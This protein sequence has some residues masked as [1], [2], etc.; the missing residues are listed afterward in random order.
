[1]NYCVCALL[2]NT[3]V[4]TAVLEIARGGMLR[5]GLPV[6]NVQAAIITNVAEDH[7]GEYGVL[8]LSDM[9]ETKFIIQHGLATDGILVLNADD[10]V[11]VNY[12][13]NV[14]RE[15]CW[16]SLDAADPTVS[17]HVKKGGK[18]CTIENGQIIYFENGIKTALLDYHRI[19]LTMDGAAV[20][21]NSNCLGAIS[22][23]KALGVENKAIADS[24]RTFGSSYTDNPGR[25]NIFKKNGY[26]ILMDFAHN[27]HGMNALVTLV[28]NIP[29]K[30]KLLLIG[31]AG[32]RN[33]DEIARLVK[34]AA[35]IKPDQ[36]I[37]AEI[38]KYLRG[39][40][41]GEIPDVISTCLQE[42]G[43]TENVIQ[44]A[45]DILDGIKKSIQ[46]A[47]QDD[48]LVLLCLDQKKEAFHY[49]ENE[50]V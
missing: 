34:S 50:V 45:D 3:D 20:H 19:P 48:L 37:I 6:K 16:F 28:N 39:R 26:T 18:A 43:L 9:V 47:E 22:L 24:L 46:Y 41:V 17:N 25:G 27:P 21:N 8:N 44:Y 15:I 23:A 12:A 36:V 5:R 7:L 40:K 13:K 1:M 35:Q 42:N 4:E 2:R 30:R 33:N 11:I 29:A 32:D 38:P 49:I 31:Q 14:T 10:A